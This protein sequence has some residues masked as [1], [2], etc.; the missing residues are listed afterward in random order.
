[1]GILRLTNCTVFGNL[2]QKGGNGGN[3]GSGGHGHSGTPFPNPPAGQPQPIGGNGGA[4]GNGGMGGSAGNGGGICNSGTLGLNSCTVVSN[5]AGGASFGGGGGLG[6]FGGYGVPPAPNGANGAAGISGC[7]GT[8]GNGGGLWRASEL[9]N[10]IVALNSPDNVQ[11]AF[12][13]VG[14][15]LIDIDPKVEF[16]NNNGGPTFTCALL[17]DS[18]AINAGTGFGVPTFDQRGLPRPQGAAVDIGAFEYERLVPCRFVLSSNNAGFGPAGSTSAVAVIA[19]AGCSW[20]V[21]NTNEWITIDSGNPGVGTGVLNY[22]V[23]PNPSTNSRM[24][25]LFVADQIFIV[26]QAGLA[27][28]VQDGIVAWGANDFGQFNIP[29][30]LD[31]VIAVAAGVYHNLALKA[32]GAVVAWGGNQFGESDVPVELSSIVAIAAGWSTSLALKRDGTVLGWGW[33]GVEGCRPP[34]LSNVVAIAA[35]WDHVLA[36]KAD[37]NVVAWGDYGPQTNVPPSLTN[38]VAI[39]GGAYHSL[40]LQ[41]DGTV[42]SW[43]GLT[44]VPVALTNVVAIAGGRHHSLALQHDGTVLAWNNE[45]AVSLPSELTNIVAITG[46]WHHDLA[47]RADGMLIAWGD[48]TYGQTSLPVF[49]PNVVAIAAGGNHNLA[50]I[51][52]E[53]PPLRLLNPVCTNNVF[54]AR[55][56]TVSGRSYTL[57][58]KDGPSQANWIALPPIPGN[59]TIKVVSDPAANMPQRFYRVRQQ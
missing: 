44:N 19:V 12:T 5:S 8:A 9:L 52:Q 23:Q 49:L 37:G 47:L 26:T 30:G 24:G 11:G 13:N 6:G 56:Q 48:N 25:L 39:A 41:R 57:E 36:L 10:T 43:G 42:K 50:L 46:G 18:P 55:V 27:P 1:M 21:G 32:D 2:C 15:N 34:G 7:P 53:Q 40:A 51:S 14:T 3:G 28:P 58:F 35:G 33:S 59:G 22:A 16:L 20:T 29:A 38:V 31:N 4:G 17:P 54:C 45:G